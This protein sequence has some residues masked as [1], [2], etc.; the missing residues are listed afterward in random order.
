MKALRILHTESSLGWG[1]QEI[2]ILTEARAVARRGHAVTL[3]APAEARIAREAPRYGVDTATLPIGRKNLRG[4]FALR[5]YLARERF[6][7]V[8]TH[9]STD[10]WLAALA[11]ATRSP[12]PPIVR[13]RH[14][15]ASAGR[16]AATRWLYGRATARVVTTGERLRRQVIEETGVD[17]ARVVSISTGIDLAVFKPGD[18]LA[19]RAALGLPRDAAIVGIVATLRDWKGH[20]DLLRAM[21]RLSPATLLAIVGDGPQRDSLEELVAELGI[22]AR[23]RLAGEQID[24]APW[25]RSFDVF[26]LPSYANEGVPQALMQAMACAIPVVTTNV[27]SIAEIVSDGVTGVFTAPRDPQALAAV[28]GA[29]LGDA[30]RR[31]ELGARAAAAA[32][33]RFG[34]ERM[35]ERMLEVFD[36]VAARA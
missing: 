1:G 27:G 25:M 19:S 13:T 29:L 34:E 35:V 28:L 20:H 22:G 5:Q 9:S 16:N 31:A 33:E 11:C 17:A 21:A 36:T 12:A 7:V 26:C 15:S 18:R 4:L 14:I 8:N 6:D 24:V 32:R 10:S 23:V 2:R 30:T 3:A